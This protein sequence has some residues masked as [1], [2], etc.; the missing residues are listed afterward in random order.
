MKLVL[1]VIIIKSIRAGEYAEP[2]AEGP[3]IAAICGIT[4]EHLAFW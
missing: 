3:I 2:P 1:L 4:P